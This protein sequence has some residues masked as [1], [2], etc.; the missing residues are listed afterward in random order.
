M[1]FNIILN[2]MIVLFEIYIGFDRFQKQFDPLTV[3]ILFNFAVLKYFFCQDYSTAGS[4][5]LEN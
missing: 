5:E 4:K 2:Q 1:L 3:R